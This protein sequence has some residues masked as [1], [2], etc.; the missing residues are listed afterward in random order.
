M[1]KIAKFILA[2]AVAI[3]IVASCGM[4]GCKPKEIILS[5]K[6][7]SDSTIT[8][9]RVEYRDTTIIV[10]ADSAKIKAM[11]PGCPDLPE[12]ITS[13]GRVRLKISVKDGQINA[14]CLCLEYRKKLQLATWYIDTYRRTLDK[15]HNTKLITRNHVPGFV[16]FLAWTGGIMLTLLL[17]Y[18]V[19]KVVIKI[20]K[21]I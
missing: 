19:I 7:M 11:V 16:K 18:I 14:D 4:F 20:Y 3:F 8:K 10:E 12:Q 13:N 5:D 6:V 2:A 17:I 9:M 21:P 15:Q 1:V